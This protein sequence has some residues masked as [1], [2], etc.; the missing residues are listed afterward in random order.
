MISGDAGKDTIELGKVVASSIKGGA[1]SDS[2]T[3]SGKN[4]ATIR[5]RRMAAKMMTSSPFLLSQPISAS[6]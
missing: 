5:Q 4:N 3:I 1:E 2:I 6:S